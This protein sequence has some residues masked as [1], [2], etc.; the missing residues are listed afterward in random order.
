RRPCGFLIPRYRNLASEKEVSF[1]RGYNLQGHGERQEWSDKVNSLKGFGADFKEKL[2]T[3]GPWTIWMA[4]WGECLPYYENRITLDD[5]KK[6]KWGLPIIKVNFSFGE[7]EKLMMRD[8][9]NTS[10]E[11]LERAGFEDVNSFNYN[12]PGGS[13]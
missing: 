11:M 1:V 6:D 8:I 10:V 3:P 7:N 4:G 9:R 12:K 13:T 5:D 2:T